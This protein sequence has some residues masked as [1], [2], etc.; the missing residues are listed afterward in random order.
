MNG[1]LKTD[2][3]KL[4]LAEAWRM[5]RWRYVFLV[6]GWKLRGGRRYGKMLVPATSTLIRIELETVA[7]AAR[8]AMAPGLDEFQH[9]GFE[10]LF[11]Y[12]VAIQG[13]KI[14]RASC[15]ERV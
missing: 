1:Y 6:A 5:G 9:A 15:R 3:S 11:W 4:S 12:T 10:I 2:M 8:A 13:P 7:E 14:G